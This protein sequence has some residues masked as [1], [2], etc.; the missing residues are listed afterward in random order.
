VFVTAENR[1]VS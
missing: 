1:C